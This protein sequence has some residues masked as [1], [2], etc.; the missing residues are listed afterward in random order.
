MCTFTHFQFLPFKAA[1]SMAGSTRG[2]LRMWQERGSR[3]TAGTCRTSTHIWTGVAARQLTVRPQTQKPRMWFGVRSWDCLWHGAL[4]KYSDSSFF[5]PPP[6][7]LLVFYHRWLWTAAGACGD[8]GSS[9]PEHAE[10]EWSSRTGSALTPFLGTEG[11]TARDRG[12]AISP[13][14][15]SLVTT[16]RVRSSTKQAS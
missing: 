13:A 4:T 15:R 14:T 7:S 16:T 6:L 2:E 9:A 3:Q 8:H 12:S 11:S 10:V 1:G 5:F